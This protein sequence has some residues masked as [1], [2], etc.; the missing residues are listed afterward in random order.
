VGKE[1]V[2]FFVKWPEKG[3]VKTRLAREIGSEHAVNLYRCFILDLADKLKKLSQDV[4]LCYS[5]QNANAMF[6][7]WLGDQFAYFPQPDGDLGM[8]MKKSFD[9][10]FENGYK[11]AV[12]IGSDCPDLPE[13]FLKQAFT[14]LKHADAVIGPAVDGGYWLIGFQ[15]RSFYPHV[16]EGVSWSMETVFAETMKKFSQKKINA[17]VLP[18]WMD[19]DTITSLFEWYESYEPSSLRASHTWT[20]MKSMK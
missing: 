18:K 12:L 14:E 20:Y 16:F 8:R 2:L 6:R 19:I 4:I 7:S 17:A 15:S 13:E 9:Q 1:C 5:P 11:Q 3:K 10:A